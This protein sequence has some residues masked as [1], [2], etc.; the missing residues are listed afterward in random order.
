MLIEHREFSSDKLAHLMRVKSREHKVKYSGNKIAKDLGLPN[1]TIS[2]WL[3]GE[4]IPNVNNLSLLADY[5]KVPIDT[6]IT[7]KGILDISGLV[8]EYNM[9]KIF[10]SEEDLMN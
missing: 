8:D 6:F 9:N 7:V 3:S 1:A 5:F 10:L 2:R 4:N